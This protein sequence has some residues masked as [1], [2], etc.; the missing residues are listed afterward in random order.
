MRYRRGKRNAA[1][2]MTSDGFV[3]TLNRKSTTI[4]WEDISEIDAGVRDF[5]TYDTFYIVVFVGKARI[6][7]EEFDDGF[8][9]LE[10]TMLE[11][12]PGIKE[13]W[14]QLFSMPLHQAHYE[15]LWHRGD[16]R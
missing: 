9:Q 4:R 8:R 5:L 1:I 15:V 7:I 16:A 6:T 11:R 13:R 2:D 12:W 3:V 10:F 14:Q